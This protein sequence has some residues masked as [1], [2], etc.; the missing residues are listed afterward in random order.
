[1]QINEPVEVLEIGTGFF[2]AQREVFSKWKDAYP[3]FH[4]KPDHNRSEHFTG[5]RY[6]HAYFDTVIDNEKYTHIDLQSTWEHIWQIHNKYLITEIKSGIVII[7]QH[8]AH[9]RVLFEE[10]KKALDGNG[11]IS[12]PFLAHAFVYI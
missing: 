1:M 3:Q 5:D 11:F 8:V 10:A 12:L 2:M 7:D 4:Y 6:I 9:E